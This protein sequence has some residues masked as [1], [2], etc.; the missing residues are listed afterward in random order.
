M[1]PHKMWTMNEKDIRL[2]ATDLDGTLFSTLG[3]PSKYTADILK[4]LRAQGVIVVLSSG[5]PYYSLSRSVSED[6]YD[7]A[8]CMNGQDIYIPASRKH[9]R[10]KELSADDVNTLRSLFKRY[11]LIM[12]AATED[13]SVYICSPLMSAA[14]FFRD[15]PR[16][17]CRFLTKRPF[18]HREISSSLKALDGK[19]AGKICFSGTRKM[20]QNYADHLDQERF[21]CYFVNS[22]WLEVMPAGISKGNAL[23]EIMTMEG[24]TSE[25]CAAIGDGEND[26]P[27]LEVCGMKVAM[28]NAM[29]K[30]A[31]IADFRAGS[32][33]EDGCAKWIEEHLLKR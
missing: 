16:N 6:L 4:R 13:K 14:Y 27:L 30:L 32:C 15:L 10:K 7:Y 17:V 25:Q 8:S 22:H 18:V 2:F 1:I 3:S 12:N 28:K 29:P 19:P 33:I 20:L 24:L 31:E 5:R 9:I 11:P 26:I 21:S 23:K